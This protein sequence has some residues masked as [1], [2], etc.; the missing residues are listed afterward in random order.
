M[1]SLPSILKFLPQVPERQSKQNYQALFLDFLFVSYYISTQTYLFPPNLFL[2]T[3]YQHIPSPA[4]QDSDIQEIINA[5]DADT[6]RAKIQFVQEIYPILSEIFTYSANLNIEYSNIDPFPVNS[7]LKNSALASAELPSI[8]LWALAVFIS[9]ILQVPIYL[10]LLYTFRHKLTAIE[11]AKRQRAL[12]KFLDEYIHYAQVQYYNH[13]A[14]LSDADFDKLYQFALNLA[15]LNPVSSLVN[16]QVRVGAAPYQ[17]QAHLS[18]MLSLQNAYNAEDLSRWAETVYK[19][20]EPNTEV[21]WIAEP[22]FDGV[23]ISLVYE[24]DVLVRALSRGDGVN[25]DNLIDNVLQIPTIPMRVPFSKYGVKTI[26]IRGEILILRTDFAQ[27]VSNYTQAGLVAPI[28]ARNYAAGTMRLKNSDEVKKRKLIAYFY[29]IGFSAL[30][31]QL[32]FDTHYGLLEFLAKYFASPLPYVKSFTK[33]SE[34]LLFLEQ[35]ALEKSQYP[36]VIDGFVIKVNPLA[37]HQRLGS[38]AHHPRWAIAWKFPAE[39]ALTKIENIVFQVGRTGIIT[40][41]AKVKPT[42]LSGVTISSIS[43]FNEKNIQEKALH[44]GDYV[45]IERAG[46][47]IPYIKSV[48]YAMRPNDAKPIIFPKICPICQTTLV[49]NSDE[50][51]LRCP[52]LQCAAQVVERIIHF[53]SKEALDI[54]FLGV[55]KIKRFHAAGFLQ[56]IADIYALP[57]DKILQMEGLGQKSIDLLKANIEESKTAKLAKIILGLGIRFIGKTTAQKISQNIQ[58]LRELENWSIEDWESI[59]DIGPKVAASAFDF[60]HNQ[61]NLQLLNLLEA[62]GL[63]LD[64]N[65][66]KEASSALT[67][68]SSKPL[69][70]KIFLF[71]GTLTSYTRSEAQNIVEQLG[72]EVSNSVTQKLTH[73]VAGENAGQKLAKAQKLTNITIINEEEFKKLL[74]K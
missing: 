30:E 53:A 50:I 14:V 71:T 61:D 54:K 49:K 18:P 29:H 55:E 4:M 16:V 52:S 62:R 67:H 37:L 66:S 22:K 6:L 34:L 9:R 31:G 72:A 63:V 41:V 39:T 28:N 12:L 45:E 46:E 15:K 48:N 3:V 5:T 70:G 13:N 60:F 2:S 11:Q 73:L 35:I 51:A 74:Q 58:H 32:P 59:S 38:T 1:Y 7:L 56:S 40:P 65:I 26:E 43:L 68:S 57:Y 24:D 17:S 64:K 69:A 8:Y 42:Y 19:N 36:F 47:V 10:D 25:G 23:S 21:S 44:I 27:I 20:L 33:I